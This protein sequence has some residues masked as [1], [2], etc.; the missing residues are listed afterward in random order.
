[1]ELVLPFVP[2]GD[3]QLLNR[4]EKV[5]PGS[6]KKKHRSSRLMSPIRRLLLFVG[7]FG[8]APDE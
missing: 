8:K 3:T 6:Q 7:L 1:M 5:I 4:P 2:D